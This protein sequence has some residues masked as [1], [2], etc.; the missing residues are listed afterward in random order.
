VQ[1]GRVVVVVVDVVVDDVVDV[2][3]E[4]VDVLLVEEDIS[5]S[6]VVEAN[7]VKGEGISVVVV[8]VVVEVV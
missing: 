2:V 5:A 7:E 8:V 6:P 3:V 1:G 4:D